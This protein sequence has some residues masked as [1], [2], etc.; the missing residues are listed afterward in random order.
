MFK[1]A[2]GDG[3]MELGELPVQGVEMWLGKNKSNTTDENGYYFFEDVRA[4]KAYVNI[5]TSTVPSGFLL[6]GPATQEVVISHH[7]ASR[8]DFGITSRTEIIGMVFYDTNGNTRFDAGDRG[9]KA[10]VLM[11]DDGSAT[12]TSDTGWYYFRKLPPGEYKITLDL[13]SLPA[14]YLPAVPIF[15]NV[16]LFEG[17]S[18]HFNIPLKKIK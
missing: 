1:D 10:V 12:E 3:L 13:D 16:E 18:Y 4:R 7:Q 6:T 15:R 14:E 5:N 9:I 17:S 11:L 8:A 2:N